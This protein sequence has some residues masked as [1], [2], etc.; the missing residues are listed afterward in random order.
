MSGD[1]LSSEGEHSNDATS[2]NAFRPSRRTVLAAVAWTVPVVIVGTAAPALASASAPVQIGTWGPVCRT[3]TGTP[4]Y[5]ITTTWTNT[6][7]F[8][9]TVKVIDLSVNGTSYS[10]NTLPVFKLAA[11]TTGVVQVI[12]VGPAPAATSTV[13]VT[14]T[15]EVSYPGS[16]NRYTSTSPELPLGVCT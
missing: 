10:S 7:N 9:I 2:S 6:Y 4:R 13:S 14:I 8:E 5:R 16:R 1:Q 3:A 11:T 12:E 15:Y